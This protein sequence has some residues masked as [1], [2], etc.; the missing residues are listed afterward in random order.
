MLPGLRFLLGAIALS[1][2]L[3][4]FGLGATALL[5]AA[6]HEFASLPSR[7][8]PPEPLFTPQSDAV[9]PSLAMLRVDNQ[10][11]DNQ[12]AEATTPADMQV[13]PP[14]EPSMPTPTVPATESQKIETPLV[15]A[16]VLEESPRGGMHDPQIVA[17]ET[18]AS[19]EPAV[20]A[21][22]S[23]PV[24]TKVAASASTALPAPDPMPT[25]LE[26]TDIGVTRDSV[27]TKIATLGGP[28]VEIE[29]QPSRVKMRAKSGAAD[30]K[31]RVRTERRVLRRKLARR[32]I[33][34]RRASQAP[35]DPFGTASQFGGLPGAS[36]RSP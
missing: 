34:L 3:L 29:A 25:A 8:A 17:S 32:G 31:K 20:A 18:I 9:I 26:Q 22:A 28:A 19:T 14:V 15:A 24:E 11:T 5:R 10:A 33:A 36:S 30:I 13:A 1:T 23:F 7:P 35:A 2:S 12:A 21:A 16:P 6:H 4:I 27:A